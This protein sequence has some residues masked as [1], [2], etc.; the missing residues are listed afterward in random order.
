[1]GHLGTISSELITFDFVSFTSSSPNEINFHD[2]I[3][4]KPSKVSVIKN[5]T[6]LILIHLTIVKFK[7]MHP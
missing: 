7:V 6:Y 5:K 3:E 4:N 1:M 2:I